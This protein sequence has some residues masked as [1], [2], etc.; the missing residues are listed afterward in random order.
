MPRSATAACGPKA[1]IQLLDRPVK[2]HSSHARNASSM[3]PSSRFVYTVRGS[4]ALGA[5][6]ALRFPVSHVRH[7]AFLFRRALGAA[8][9]AGKRIGTQSTNDAP[10]GIRGILQDE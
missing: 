7:S 2:K 6:V 9:L 3:S 10:C 4:G 8:G 5:L 1:S